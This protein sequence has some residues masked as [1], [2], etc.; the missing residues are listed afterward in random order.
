MPQNIKY[1]DHNTIS[2]FVCESSRLKILTNL[3]NLW[4]KNT[5]NYGTDISTKN[6]VLKKFIILTQYYIHDVIKNSL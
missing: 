6:V 5:K 2:H 1:S 4:S 3:Q